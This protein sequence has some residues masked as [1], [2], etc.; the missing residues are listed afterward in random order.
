MATQQ[1]IAQSIFP[2][3]PREIPIVDKEGKLTPYWDLGFS[4]LFQALQANFKN[5]GI[6]FPRL[7]D[8]QLATIQALYEPFVGGSYNTLT[9]NLPDISGQTTFDTT[10]KFTNQFVIATNSSSIVTLA[11]WVPLAVMLTYPGNPDTN[12]AGVLNWLCY[13]TTDKVL[14]VCYLAGAAGTARWSAL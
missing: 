4:A 3:L 10:T 14:Y 7:T 13:D 11:E 8:T 9:Q 12:L 6:L 1:L 5:E 2:D